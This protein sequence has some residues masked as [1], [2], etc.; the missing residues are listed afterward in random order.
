LWISHSVRAI[1]ENGLTKYVLGNWV[2]ITERKK[3]EEALKESEA[4][5][6]ILLDDA[7]NP[8]IVTG[9]DSTIIYVN[10]AMEKLTGF[11]NSELVGIKSP[12]PWWDKDF[13][14]YTSPE[15]TPDDSNIHERLC[16][17]KDGEPF[18]I[19]V[20]LKI[21][22]DNGEIKYHIA[23]CVDITAGREHLRYYLYTFFR[24]GIHLRFLCLDSVA[25]SPGHPGS[26]TNIRAIRPPGGYSHM[27]G[28]PGVGDKDRTAA[29]RYRIPRAACRRIVALAY[30]ECFGI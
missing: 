27:Q 17:K 25:W 13:R 26:R 22:R 6:T 5:K 7:P 14:P 3:A 12:Y 30:I 21:I 1:R 10:P 4:F 15:D 18:W 8:I 16:K 28:I 19:S 2:D 11:S 29:G 24:W 23:N 9:Q 20:Y